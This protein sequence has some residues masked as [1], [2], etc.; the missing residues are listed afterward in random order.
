MARWKRT[1]NR[2]RLRRST[3]LRSQRVIK[4]KKIALW[5]RYAF[6]GVAVLLVISFI[7]IPLFAFNLPSPDKIV[8]RDGFSTKILDRNGEVLYDIFVDER[9]TP[10]ELDDIPL[11]L[12][13]A[14]IAIEDKNFY[15]HKGFDPTGFFR[16]ILN[17]VFRGRIQGGST[18]TQQLVKNALLSPERTI[19]RKVREF[20]LSIQI[21]R[22]YSKDEI[23]KMYLNEVP[24][25]G[26][27]FGVETAAETYYGKKVKD[28]NLVESAIL[29]GLPQR[30]SAYSPYSSTPDAYIGRTEQVLRRMR[31]DD[32]I[33]K[34]QEESALGEIENVKFQERGASFK[35]PHFVQYVQKILEDR[36][37]ENVVEQGGLKVT[38][39]LDLEL[40]ESAEDTVKEE[41]DKVTG[42]K[43][44]NG[45]AVVLDPETGEILAMVGSRGFSDPDI[46][47]QVNVTTR[48]RQ[49][50]SAIKPI[51]YLTAFKEGYTASSLIMDVPTTFPGGIGQPD[52]EPVNYDGEYRG[53]M[54]LRYTLGNSINVAAVKVLAL[55]GIKDTLQTAYD[56]GITSL[57]PTNEMMNKVGL[58]LT[59]GGGEV[60]LLEL[61]GAYSTFMNGGHVVEPVGILKVEDKDGKVLEEH[62]P[63][64]GKRVISEELAYMIFDILSDNSARTEIFGTNSLLNIPGRDIA[65]K[66][67]TTNDKRDNWTVGGGPQAVVGVWVGNNDNSPMLQVASGVTGASPIWR[68]IVMAALQGKSNTSPEV[69]SGIITAAVDTIS[70]YRAHDGFPSRIEQFIK[71]TEPGEDPIHAKLKV[72]KTDGKLATPSDV[73]A[74]NYDEKEYFVFKEEDPTAGSGG[75]NRWQEGINEWLS[76]QGD[77]RYHPPSDYCGTS[78]PVNVEFVNP[79]DRSSNLPNKFTIEVRADSTAN[80]VQIELEVDG[81]KVRT[82]TGPP[83][84]HEVDLA[85]GVHK[86]RAKARD[87]KGKESDRTITIGVNVTWDFSPTPIPTAAP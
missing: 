83:F 84:K 45:A 47:G 1:L 72:C 43:I 68:R 71:G 85:D 61:T 32:Y 9:R 63:E 12:R 27:A 66:T 65:V 42:L 18:L 11:F 86:L 55:V 78:N 73:A 41:I 70:G 36:Y 46:D 59:L 17:I 28:L 10:V 20:L 30:P 24:Y 5:S 7:A 16:A 8:R 58:S 3:G 49:P 67:G 38:T 74:G 62:E 80:I 87:E 35:A 54:Q 31:E 56:L 34:E 26:T 76:S 6:I 69:P 14:T 44:S 52:Y 82:F 4:S 75:T 37:G 50:G 53:P 77:G 22:K 13:Q 39:T 23:L 25:G 60:K 79:T 15:E 48:L 21:E 29:A 2:R 33:T 51:T 40:Q 19:F 64:K 57:K 81:T